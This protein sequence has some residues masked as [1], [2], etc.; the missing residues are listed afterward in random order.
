MNDPYDTSEA[1]SAAPGG[2]ALRP[3]LWILL[4]VGLA[5]NVVVSGIGG[6]LIGNVVFGLLTVGGAAAL[7]VQHYRSRRS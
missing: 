1:P 6:N 3:L 4:V 2:A 7:I 5:G